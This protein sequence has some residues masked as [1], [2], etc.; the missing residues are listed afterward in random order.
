MAKSF[1]KR[2]IDSIRK[3]VGSS[4]YRVYKYKIFGIVKNRGGFKNE[5]NVR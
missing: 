4:L 2:Y 3:N 5:R 1:E